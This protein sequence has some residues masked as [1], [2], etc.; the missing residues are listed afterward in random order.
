M[1]YHF[2]LYL[3]HYFSFL[4]V[5][6]Y[7][8]VR[9]VAAL[10][11]ALALSLLLGDWF[12][13]RCGPYLRSS[14]RAFTPEGHRSKDRIP[15]MGGIFIIG[16]VLTSVLLWCDLTEAKVWV[17]LLCLLGFGAIGGWDD[18][19]KIRYR[20]GLSARGKFI[21]QLIVAVA[22]TGA[23][24]LW[25]KSCPSVTIPFFKHVAL[26]L[27]P[28][29]A[30]WS[31]FIL[32]GSSNAVNL[33][34]GLD[35]LAT[36]SLIFN[37]A[38]FSLIAYM[39]GHSVIASYLHIPFAATSEVAIVG[40]ALLGSCLGFLWYNTYPAQIFMGDI[41]SLALGATWALMGLMAKQELLL[42]IAGGLFVLETGSVMIQVF[43]YKRWGKRVL[44]MAPIHHHFELLGWQESKITVRFGII[45]FILCLLALITLKLR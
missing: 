15:T 41:G 14:S 12:I 38:T 23:W 21:L 45:T 31:I 24:L 11:T 25:V 18:W 4:N 35:G 27:G 40:A 5:I 43:A 8:S 34:D 30:L 2:S 13:G 10:L 22:V 26:N 29:F 44:K 9:G 42:P 20:T 36:G 32:V 1:I 39:A 16:V 19:L 33:T 28:I 7:V 6:H 3:K 37:F 17:L